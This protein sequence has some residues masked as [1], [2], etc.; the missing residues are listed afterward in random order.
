[1]KN[2]LEQANVR[3]ITTAMVYALNYGFYASD[4]IA[5]EISAYVDNLSGIFLIYLIVFYFIFFIGPG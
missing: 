2:N 1:M 3:G 5:S 4:V